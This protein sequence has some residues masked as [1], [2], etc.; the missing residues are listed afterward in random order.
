ML[1]YIERQRRRAARF[2]KL[3]KGERI[4]RRRQFLRQESSVEDILHCWLWGLHSFPVKAFWRMDWRRRV[5]RWRLA[6]TTDSNSSTTLNR[7][8]TSPKIR[9]C[10]VRNESG[11]VSGVFVGG[12]ISKSVVFLKYWMSVSQAG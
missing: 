9:V 3:S 8:S 6:D 1:A 12:W 5:A 11:R 4:E 2:G 10:S 7:R